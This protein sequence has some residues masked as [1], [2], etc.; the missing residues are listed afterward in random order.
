METAEI[1]RRWLQ[2]FGDRGHTV[3]PSASL[4]L[5][6]PNL[7]FVNAGMVPFKPYLLGQQTPPYRRATSVQKCVRTLDIDEV[8][9]GRV[10]KET[11]LRQRLGLVPDGTPQLEASGRH[12]AVT[13]PDN[14]EG[15]T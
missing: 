10:E 3:V 8:A 7:L 13:G 15:S 2:F 12:R 4:L 5:D 1:K 11:E 9:Q 14:E 6:D